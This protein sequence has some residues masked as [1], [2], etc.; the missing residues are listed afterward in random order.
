MLYD[1]RWDA[2]T[3]APSLRGFIA[4]LEHQPSDEK[5]NVWNARRCALGQYYAS[6]GRAPVT[7][8]G[9][10]A[11]TFGVLENILSTVL[12]PWWPR[13]TFG[14]TLTRARAAFADR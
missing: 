7:S 3:K 2:Q 8:I 9:E 12:S 13:S 6:I 11:R 1:K 10:V 4:W 5:Y 14:A